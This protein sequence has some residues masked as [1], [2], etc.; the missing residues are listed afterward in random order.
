MFGSDEG[1]VVFLVSNSARRLNVA[2]PSRRAPT[3]SVFL[4]QLPS[5]IKRREER[6]REATALELLSET[7]EEEAAIRGCKRRLMLKRLAWTLL[8]QQRQQD[9]IF[10]FERWFHGYS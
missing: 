6:G 7:T 1:S 2:P 10:T 5:R 8:Q 3:D 4:M 9:D